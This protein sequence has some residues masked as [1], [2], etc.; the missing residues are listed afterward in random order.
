MDT[1]D[2]GRCWRAGV[3]TCSLSQ[4]ELNTFSLARSDRAVQL[5]QPRHIQGGQ[6]R[7]SVELSLVFLYVRITQVPPYEGLVPRRLRSEDRRSQK[8]CKT[9]VISTTS[10]DAWEAKQTDL[11]KLHWFYCVLGNAPITHGERTSAWRG[12]APPELHLFPGF[13]GGTL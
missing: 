5:Q 7:R 13:G 12:R 10:Q 6:A 8:R 1:F 9:S 11:L 4:W 2:A 3:Q